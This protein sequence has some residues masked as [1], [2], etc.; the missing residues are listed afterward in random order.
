MYFRKPKTRTLVVALGALLASGAAFAAPQTT[1][2]TDSTTAAS[3]TGSAQLVDRYSAFTGSDANAQALIDGLHSGNEIDLSTVTEAADGTSQSV[4]TTFTPATD[5][6]GYGE[7]NTSLSLAKESLAAAGIT[8]PTAEQIEA[9]L[10]GGTITLDDGTTTDM[11]G[12]LALRASGQGW[13]Q[14][15]QTLGVNLG[16][17]VSASHTL[18][19]QA[20]M[21]HGNAQASGQVGADAQVGSDHARV[22]AQV[23]SDAQAGTQAAVDHA[24]TGAQVVTQAGGAAKVDLPTR[25]DLPTHPDHPDRPSIPD[26]PSIPQRPDLPVHAGGHVGG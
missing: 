14:I 24:R 1:T 17:V 5:A 8:K 21:T 4:D 10:N 7:V 13:G 2:S 3:A 19:S 6:M 22:G 26:H 12:V 20:G 11:Q 25:P 23:A 9:A 15:A 18:N 16:A